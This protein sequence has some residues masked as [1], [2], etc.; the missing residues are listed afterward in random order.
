M[1]V[2]QE[3]GVLL[4][5]AR[6]GEGIAREEL[7][8]RFRPRLEG[9]LR[10]RLPLG[11]RDLLETQDLVQDVCLKAFGAID[12]FEHRG[13]GS[14]WGF[15]RQIA[16]RQLIDAGRR[17][18]RRG[19]VQPLDEDSRG[20]PPARATTPLAHLVTKESIEAF[21]GALERVGEKQREAL[22]MRLELGLDFRTIAV[23]C[24][25]PTEA[26]ARMAVHRALQR[27]YAEMNLGGNG[28]RGGRGDHPG[29]RRG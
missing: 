18:G 27:V 7:F 15:L 9:F 20:A 28:G 14:F 16:L 13:I 8:R 24:G 22:L 6:V 19:G 11:A 29:D 17:A 4:S 3:T 26:A 5:R 10:S 2:L 25:F 21:E 12:R 23:E 1:A